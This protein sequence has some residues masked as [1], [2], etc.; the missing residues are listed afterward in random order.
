MLCN[1]FSHLPPLKYPGR[2]ARTNWNCDRGS[3]SIPWSNLRPR[4]TFRGDPKFDMRNYC[5]QPIIL[6]NFV[7]FTPCDSKTN[8]TVRINR[9]SDSRQI[10]WI[11]LPCAP[12]PNG[13][14]FQNYVRIIKNIISAR[15]TILGHARA[16]CWFANA[17]PPHASNPRL[18]RI[19]C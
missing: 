14:G 19:V 7:M 16:L 2:G 3:V 17:H 4:K 6:I 12:S 8:L 1:N 13:L 18:L 10:K 11:R 5:L 15:K 9:I